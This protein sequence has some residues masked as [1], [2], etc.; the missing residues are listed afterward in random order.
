MNKKH[1]WT[2]LSF[3][4]AAWVTVL[5]FSMFSQPAVSAAATGSLTLVITKTNSWEEGGKVHSQF[6]LGI[7]NEGPTAAEGW[8]IS[9]IVPEG[10]S[11]GGSDG[12]NGT[13]SLSGTTL[14]ITPKE[15]N[16]QIAAGASV[17]DIGFILTTKKA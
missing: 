13:F 17:S 16:Y 7:T 12:W 9:M 15:Y 11:M 10:S 14:T 6:A 8:I 5:M 3:I 2:A 1:I 4:S